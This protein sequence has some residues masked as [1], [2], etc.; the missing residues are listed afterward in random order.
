M[1]S[2]LKKYN[3]IW[4][5]LYVVIYMPW[6]V[7]LERNVVTNYHVVHSRLDDL[8][9][10]CEYFIIPYYLWFIFI[11]SGMALLF[12]TSKKD[13]YNACI[14]LFSGMTIF[15]ITCTLWHNGQNLRPDV[16]PRNNMFCDMVQKLYKTDTNTNVF[17][18]IHV[19]NSI[20]ICIALLKSEWLSKKDTFK[21]LKRFIKIGAIILATLI[22]LATMFLK[23]HSIVDVAGA[24]ILSILF[25]YIVYVY[26]IYSRKHV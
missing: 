14:F 17:P 12:F 1:K 5:L 16:L 9:P 8:I 2:L 26:K 3:H 10:F 7:L 18:S 24:I 19:Y 20:G 15:L 25:Y 23:Q 13:Y 21:T 22:I 6:F 4:T 11:A